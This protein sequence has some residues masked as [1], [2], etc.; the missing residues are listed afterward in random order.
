MEVVGGD[1][2]PDS[3]GTADTSQ[4]MAPVVTAEYAQLLEAVEA[5][6]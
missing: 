5:A 1:A 4:T 2:T 6:S 3:E